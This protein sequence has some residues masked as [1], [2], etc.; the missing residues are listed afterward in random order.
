MSFLKKILKEE[1]PADVMDRLPALIK[2][3]EQYMIDCRRTVHR[4]A[5]VGGKETK[6]SGFVQKEAEALG[7][8]VEKVSETGLLITMDTGRPGNGVVL[9]AELDALPIPESPDN[10][11]GPK[12]VISD[13]PET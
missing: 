11:K 5:E 13:D 3:N 4:F 9:R 6:T 1:S 10:M 12:C 7:L 8:P 2:E